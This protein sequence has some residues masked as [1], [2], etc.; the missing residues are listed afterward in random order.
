MRKFNPPQLTRRNL[1]ATLPMTWLSGASD[2]MTAAEPA[3]V[4]PPYNTLSEEEEIALGRKFSAEYE[5]Q[6][7]ILHHPVID[8]Y[9]TTVV[10]TLGRYSRHPS[11]PYRVK[12]VNTREINACTVPGG[13]IFVQR[14]LLEFIGEES[15]LAGALAHEV[16]H[17]VARHGT[18]QMM[19][20]FLAR[21][22]YETVKKNLLLNNTIVQRIIEQL[23]GPVVILAQL[24][25]T[26]E[27]ETEAD[28]L[29]FYEM[30]RAGWHPNGMVKFFNRIQKFEGP[31]SLVDEILSDHPA[32]A[33]RTRVITKELQTAT[34]PPNLREQSIS[35]KSM[36]AVLK[37]LPPAPPPSKR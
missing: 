36:K 24:K 9:L 21:N 25:Y 30:V 10:K 5:K 1:L 14:G 13:F 11:W 17:A 19:L 6:V 8:S 32:S 16:G 27:N 15:E 33:E 26:R 4:I 2:V 12:V 29:G 28:L 22:L 35:F 20:D 31:Q 3:V 23:G 18:N 7:E 37:S 34:L